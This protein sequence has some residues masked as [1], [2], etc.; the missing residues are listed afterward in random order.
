M[1]PPINE[2]TF[3]EDSVRSKLA[4]VGLILGLDLNNPGTF[5]VFT[6]WALEIGQVMERL[7]GYEA[8]FRI[9]GRDEINFTAH[10]TTD[11]GETALF[12][13]LTALS[14]MPPAPTA[15]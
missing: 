2:I 3:D 10:V 9:G 11:L 1:T 12:A 15:T 14:T 4:A 5:P 6:G 7:E 8:A 13:A